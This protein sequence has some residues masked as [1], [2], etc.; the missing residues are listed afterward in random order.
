MAGVTRGA[1]KESLLNPVKTKVEPRLSLVKKNLILC[2]FFLYSLHSRTRGSFYGPP[3]SGFLWFSSL[4]PLD[5][6][7]WCD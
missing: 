5:G 4:A 3:F 6:Y 1:G 2:R 7:G